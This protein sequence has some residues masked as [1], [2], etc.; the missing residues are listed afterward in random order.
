MAVQDVNEISLKGLTQDEM[1]AAQAVRPSLWVHRLSSMRARSRALRPQRCF[2]QLHSVS[3]RNLGAHPLPEATPGVAFRVAWRVHVGFVPL[4]RFRLQKG[5]C[6]G[7]YPPQCWRIKYA[8]NDP[9]GSRPQD[10]LWTCG[11]CPTAPPGNAKPTGLGIP[12]GKASTAH[13]STSRV[14]PRSAAR[15]STVPHVPPAKAP[16]ARHRGRNDC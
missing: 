4:G 14:M 1:M 7:N 2:L 10:A 11:S 5:A 12:P 15:Y 6:S 13:C 16:T 3:P 8:A 9:S